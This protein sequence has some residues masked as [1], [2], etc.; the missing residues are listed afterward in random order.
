M[1]SQ[2]TNPANEPYEQLK[3]KLL[4][5]LQ[6]DPFNEELVVQV[7]TAYNDLLQREPIV[8][9]RNEKMRLIRETLQEIIDDILADDAWSS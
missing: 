1:N 7:K 5:R 8:F 4:L 2:M 3:K 9:T 6:A